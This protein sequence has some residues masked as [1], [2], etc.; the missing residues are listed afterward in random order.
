MLGFGWRTRGAGR[1][2]SSGVD[3]RYFLGVSSSLF[4]ESLPEG[5]FYPD[6]TSLTDYRPP[7]F[8]SL[9][10]LVR[11]KPWS[12]CTVLDL[13]CGE[14]TSTVAMG[15]TGARVIG[16]EG[17]PE[18]VR[19]A[20]YLRDRLGYSNVEFRTGSVLDAS[21][22]EQVD[23]VFVSGLIHHLR[24]P[25]QLIEL[26]GQYC[27][28]FAYFCTHLAPRTEAER[29]GSHFAAV[30]RDAGSKEF[31]GR[32]L[33]GI[34]FSEGRDVRER[35]A[36]RRRHPRAGIGNAYS[37]WLAED[38]LVEALRSV[39]FGAHTRL[40][41]NSHR[42]RYRLCFGRSNEAPRL[43]PR[44]VESL[45]AVSS[46]PAPDVAAR[47]T[48]AADLA[49]LRRAKVT[50][51]VAGD[52]GAVNEILSELADA[53]VDPGIVYLPG[54]EMPFGGTTLK[55]R[56]LARLASDGPAYVVLASARYD[57]LK[58]Q[59]GELVTLRRCRYAFS[60]FSLVRMKEFPK[61]MDP[62]TGDPIPPEL[63]GSIVY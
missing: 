3:A 44:G 34:W 33:P 50:P 20:E 32:A 7:E 42:L 26:I 54:P 31:R 28:E 49:F 10:D 1:G 4:S 38:S 55:V 48:Y 59:V 56:D 53:K 47:R 13:G 52:V 16:I 43:S 5:I 23:A 36:S 30:L 15:R 22:W 8:V 39:G 27:S 19:R 60:S 62:V 2:S 29:A 61:P 24:E 57:D 45:W 35:Q 17:R 14:G 25:F 18:V 21:L 40:Y 58:R 37:W 9:F 12:R 63:D 46:K 11:G 6:F 41:G 51:A